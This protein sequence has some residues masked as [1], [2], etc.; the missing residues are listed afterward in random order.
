M[1]PTISPH[2]YGEIIYL[3]FLACLCLWLTRY[4]EPMGWLLVLIIGESDFLHFND[5]TA[6]VLVM[7]AVAI[8]A[9]VWLA[10][11]FRQWRTR[12]AL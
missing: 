1:I 9:M 7:E 6:I 5:W 4:D 3:G 10:K 11:R 8:I 12:K 2:I